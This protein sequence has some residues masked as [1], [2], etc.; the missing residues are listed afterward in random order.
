MSIDLNVTKARL[1]AI[2]QSRLEYVPRAIARLLKEDI[3]ALITEVEN[4]RHQNR[5]M[6]DLT[7]VALKDKREAGNGSRP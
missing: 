6:V 3:P 1:G 2:P 4:L 5:L 7:M